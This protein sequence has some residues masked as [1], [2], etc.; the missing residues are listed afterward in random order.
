MELCYLY[1]KQNNSML[2]ILRKSLLY[3]RKRFNKKKKIKTKNFILI[4]IVNLST[5][6][7]FYGW[8]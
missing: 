1:A 4:F 7:R 5:L 3:E 2:V 6:L 8:S